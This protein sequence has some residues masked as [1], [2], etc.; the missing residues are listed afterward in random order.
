MKKLGY[1]FAVLAIVCLGL[2]SLMASADSCVPL[3]GLGLAKPCNPQGLK[4]YGD[5]GTGQSVGTTQ[6]LITS[7]SFEIGFDNPHNSASDLFIIA[8]FYNNPVAGS[9]NSIGFTSLPSDPFSVQ[10]GAIKD[11]IIGL[12]FATAGNFDPTKFSYGWLDLG[13][14]VDD[15]NDRYTVN[16]SGVAPG[17]IF[18]VESVNPFQV[19]IGS[20]TVCEKRNKQGVCTKSHSEP[21]YGNVNEI[22]HINAPSEGGV[23]GRPPA[24]PEPTS[25]L[26]LGSGLGALFL[27]RFKK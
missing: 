7:G 15:G 20:N 6:G 2:A 12:N 16:M 26:L 27:R 23:V 18:F 10:N 21:I 8:A 19:Q 25:L 24:T 22:D 9:L 14:G 11:T 1:K 3:K 4:I 17:T 5:S 13:H